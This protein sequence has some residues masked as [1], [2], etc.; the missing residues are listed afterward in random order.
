MTPPPDAPANSHDHRLMNSHDG[1]AG[2]VVP[3]PNPGDYLAT[4]HHHR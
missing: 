3:L 4:D 2:A 1:L